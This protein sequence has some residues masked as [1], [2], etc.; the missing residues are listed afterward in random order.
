[1]PHMGGLDADTL[2]LFP[3]GKTGQARSCRALGH[4]ICKYA[5]QARLA[6]VSPHDL[7]HRFGYRMVAVAPL[8]C[9]PRT[10]PW[11]AFCIVGCVFYN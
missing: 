5:T 11:D 7:R 4:L 3:S 6:D 2:Y 8:P 10:L 9:F 1:M